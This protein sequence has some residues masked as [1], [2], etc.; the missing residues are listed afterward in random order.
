MCW[1]YYIHFALF[2]NA[3][4]AANHAAVF[5]FVV[6]LRATVILHAYIMRLNVCLPKAA[7][8][9]V[10]ILVYVFV[11]C[12]FTRQTVSELQYGLQELMDG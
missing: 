12:I 2:N 1:V 5:A 8:C 6:L 4:A 10:E 3:V 7:T 11:V 9:F